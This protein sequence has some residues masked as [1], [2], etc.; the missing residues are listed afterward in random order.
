[1]LPRESSRPGPHFG[2][3]QGWRV[4]DEDGSV[5]KLSHRGGEFR[6]VVLLELSC[7]QP[8]LIDSAK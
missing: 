3:R 2:G 5:F 4:I 7:P 1:M 6:P 8:R